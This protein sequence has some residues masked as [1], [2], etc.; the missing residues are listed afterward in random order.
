[1]PFESAVFCSVWSWAGAALAEGPLRLGLSLQ[2]SLWQA[3][4]AVGVDKLL[5]SPSL[6]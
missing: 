1:M 5:A 4:V 6:C 2:Q 3:E